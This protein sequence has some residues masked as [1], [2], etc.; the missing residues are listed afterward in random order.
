M[1]AFLQSLYFRHVFRLL[2]PH[3]TGN[4]FKFMT[5][6]LYGA[7]LGVEWILISHL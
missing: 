1:S 6:K 4:I 5:Y 7:L 3:V 2:C